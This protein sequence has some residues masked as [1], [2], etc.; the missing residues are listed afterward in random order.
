MGAG[1]ETFGQRLRDLRRGKLMS[2]RELADRVE[3]DF[4]YLSKIENDRSPPPSA[5]KIVQLAEVLETD[6]DELAILAG[7][8]PADLVDVFKR[9]PDAIR[10]FRSLAGDLSSPEDMRRRLSKR[11]DE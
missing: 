1:E 10:L 3:L 4:T 9:N 6:P 5:K 2:Q 11:Q 7:K 8:I